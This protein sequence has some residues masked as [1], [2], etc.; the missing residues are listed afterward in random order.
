MVQWADESPQIKRFLPSEY[1]TDI[2]YSLASANEKP[3]QQ[4]LKVRA[5]I[6]E[7]KNL[8]YAFVVTGPYADVPFYLGASKN[9]RGGSF[10]V[11]N[12]KAVLL[13]DGNGRISLVACA[14][15]VFHAFWLLL[16]MPRGIDGQANGTLTVS[17]NS[18]CIP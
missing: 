1:G 16:T 14:E 10:D 3:H 12:K 18:S 5:A 9:P 2:E 6:R 7:T 17:V 13:G 11:K 15:Y 4:K 8:E